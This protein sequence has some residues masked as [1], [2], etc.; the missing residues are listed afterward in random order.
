MKYIAS[1]PTSPPTETTASADITTAAEVTAN[2]ITAQASS[3]GLTFDQHRTQFVIT[4]GTVPNDTT[5]TQK[6]QFAYGTSV[7]PTNW[8]DFPSSGTV[9]SVT[10]TGQ[11]SDTTFYVRTRAISTVT[12]APGTASINASIRLNAAF[13]P[14]PTIAFRSMS[15]SSY[16]T[17]QFT[18]SGN[19]GSTTEVKIVRRTMPNNDNGALF[20]TKATG[21]QDISGYTSDGGTE[22]YAA[23]NYNRHGEQS[24]ASNQIY[25]TRPQKDVDWSVADETSAIYFS[26]T[27]SFTSEFRYVFGG[28]IP[29]DNNVP[30][31]YDVRSLAVDGIQQ[32]GTNLNGC[33]GVVRT[34]ANTS[35]L[36][37]Q[38]TSA[39]PDFYA[40]YSNVGWTTHW[41]TGSFS[42]RS[43][44]LTTYGGSALNNT[45]WNVHT[46]IGYRTGSGAVG[47]PSSGTTLNG[48]RMKNFVISGKRTT[49]G[50]GTGF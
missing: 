48:F 22:Y 30:G 31:Y 2:A 33:S 25:W 47:C 9:R 39:H 44:T 49:T 21:S 13:P 10:I 15:S 20:V 14:T 43:V 6:Y 17:A 36:Y 24:V 11:T 38:T 40:G 12:A 29:D 8:A 45:V 34:L 35:T 32:T 4:C 27:Q 28:G 1:T 16:G 41:P 18:I 26:D 3:T 23:Y 37:W 42:T 19:A 46:T 50:S 7:G 5:Y